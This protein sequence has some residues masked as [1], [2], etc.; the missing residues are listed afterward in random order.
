MKSNYKIAFFFIFSTILLISCTSKKTGNRE[1]LEKELIIFH[2]GSLSV[3]F[4]QLAD[5]FNKENPEVKVLLE[6]AGSTECARKITELKKPC[7]IIASSDY[8]VIKDILIPEFT[9]WY[10]NFAGNEMGIAYNDKSAMSDKISK[11][12][13]FDILLTDKVIYGRSNPNLDPC[14]YRTIFTFLLSEKYYLKKGLTNKLIQKDVNFIRPKEVDLL[15]QLE[16]HTVDYIFI[17]KSVAIQHKL[18]FLSL[19]DE[20]NQSNPSFTDYYS[21]AKTEVSGKEKGLKTVKKAEPMLYA[22]S[23]MKNAPHKNIA[24][25]FIEFLLSPKGIS[26]MQANGQPSMNF[27]EKDYIQNVPD[28]I[29]KY[30]KV[31]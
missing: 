9:D 7:D 1:N 6:G 11:D 14:G 28:S 12:N 23:I 18:K 16:S 20:I 29:R 31:Q 27:V 13:W 2:A 25:K 5:E 24:I 10:V 26:I 8:T 19:P 22:I 17:Y 21:T 4:H 15:A 30:I 3:P